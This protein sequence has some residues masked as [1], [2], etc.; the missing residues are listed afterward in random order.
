MSAP[1]RS[2]PRRGSKMRCMAA[3][4]RKGRRASHSFSPCEVGL[5]RL[6]HYRWPKSDKSDFG[7]RRWDEHLCWESSM[8]WRLML[9][10][11]VFVDQGISEDDELSGDRDA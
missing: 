1:D 3:R 5:A 4:L 7:W 11:S 10:S 9:P 6:R 2:Q 8:F